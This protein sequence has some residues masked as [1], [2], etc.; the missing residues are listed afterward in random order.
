M[1][2]AKGLLNELPRSG[3]ELRDAENVAKLPMRMGGLGLRWAER[4]A[5]VAYWASWADALEMINQRVPAVANM[6]V[7][8]ME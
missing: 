1:D 4:W 5:D 8:A 2:T 6:V 7:R 3:E